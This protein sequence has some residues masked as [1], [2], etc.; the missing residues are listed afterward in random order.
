[1][2]DEKMTEDDFKVEEENN[3]SYTSYETTSDGDNSENDGKK[4]MLKYVFWGAIG[5]FA[6]LLILVV[7]VSSRSSN[8]DADNETE[9]K[10]VKM[11]AGDKI[12]LEYQSESFSWNG[13]NNSV[14]VITE[15]GQI[16]ALKEGDTVI[17]IK[18]DDATYIVNVHVEGTAYTVTSIELDKEVIELKVDDIYSLKT[19]INP[20][21]AKDTE[22]TWHSSNEKVAKVDNKGTVTA[23]AVGTSTITVK[24]GN[25]NTAICIVKVTA[26]ED[27]D[28]DFDK[29]VFDVNSIVLKDGI[30][31]TID[32]SIEPKDANVKLIWESSD[33]KVA[34]V[35][36]GIIQTL[37]PG[38]TT[39]TAKKAN[40]EAIV[41]VTVVKGDSS[42]PDVIDDGKEIKA[43][44]INMN[45]TEL[46][47]KVSQDYKLTAE[48][49]PS[50]T[51]NKAV[52]YK[53]TN[54]EV[55]TV[56]ATG[57]VVAVAK[58]TATITATTANGI[59][60]EVKVTVDEEKAKEIESI[61]LS[62]KNVSLSPG[63]TIQLVETYSPSDAAVE[64]I[65]WT[66]SDNNV[67]TVED[68]LVTAMRNGTATIT[69][70]SDS[71]VKATC[72]ITVNS[73]VVTVTTVNINPSSVSIRVN[74]TTQLSAEF[75]PPYA[76]NKTL[77]W[78]SSNK[79]IATVDG[80]GLV[81]GKKAGQ[82]TIFATS[83]NGVVGVATVI[84]N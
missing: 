11:A 80:N 28:D 56:D 64:K 27:E 20:P 57:K 31:Y 15:D 77:T 22:L 4:K 58:G 3:D 46:N 1:M 21:E 32:Y 24:T 42:T 13:T 17:T 10:N 26:I 78:R 72:N 75:Y 73:S 84:V 76:S 71:G 47:M 59:V 14:A 79:S 45:Q 54:T 33:T 2:N 37:A 74:G 68:G 23:L 51:T 12:T 7:L 38:T 30:K 83:S 36:D 8:T 55:A 9:E 19:I 49:L 53:S 35:E 41:Y 61:T 66:S 70:S 25:G 29:I 81:T 18:V 34:T 16:E 62:I 5:F 82:A 65:T 43:V 60:A 67:A 39:I 44:S 52:T 6:F 40:K 50:N 48:V 63:N 69:V